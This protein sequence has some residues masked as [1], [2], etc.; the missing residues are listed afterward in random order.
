MAAILPLASHRR[1]RDNRAMGDHAIA[2]EEVDAAIAAR[3]ASS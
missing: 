1:E 2:R 3:S